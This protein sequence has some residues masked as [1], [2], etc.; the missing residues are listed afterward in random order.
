MTDSISIPMVR[1]KCTRKRGIATRGE[2]RRVKREMEHKT[3]AVYK[4]YKCGVCGFFHL[5]HRRG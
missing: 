4:I 1:W 3:K 2:A 5:A